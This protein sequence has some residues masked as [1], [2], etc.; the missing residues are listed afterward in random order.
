MRKLQPESLVPDHYGLFV[1]AVTLMRF[2]L[3]LCPCVAV[4]NLLLFVRQC[5][6]SRGKTRDLLQ[7]VS[8]ANFFLPKK[9]KIVELVFYP[10]A[11]GLT[12]LLFLG[13]FF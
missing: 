2:A 5:T 1:A 12:G 8:S 7:S 3:F 9:K 13:L 10:V 6:T 4:L 11:V